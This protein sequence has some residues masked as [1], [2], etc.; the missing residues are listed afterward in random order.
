MKSAGVQII[1]GSDCG[2]YNYSFGQFHRELDSLVEAG[3][4]ASQAIVA[5]TSEA[6]NAL[7]IAD[8]VGI[9]EVGKKADL[10]VVDG[11]PTR[12]INELTR[13]AAVIKSGVRVK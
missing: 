7:G 12:N 1:G 2:W 5:G 10:L 3:F 13:V 9:L 6:A 4:T 8:Q 11:D